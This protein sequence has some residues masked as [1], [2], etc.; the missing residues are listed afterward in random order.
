MKSFLFKY[1][2]SKIYNLIFSIKLNP[3][4]LKI[5]E[6]ERCL[7]LAAKTEDIFAAA[8]GTI[9]TNRDKFSVYSLTNGFRQIIDKDLP[10]EEKVKSRKEEFYSIVEKAQISY[11]EFFEDID[12]GRLMMRYDRFKSVIVSNFDYIFVPNI[13]ETDKDS[14]A[15]AI[16]LNEL[17]KERPYKKHVKIVMYEVNSTLPM[18][19]NYNDIEDIIEEKVEYINS[20]NQLGETDFAGNIKCLNKF[21][22]GNVHK[23]YAEAFC[24]LGIDEFRKICRLYTENR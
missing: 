9:L 12:E 24:V 11:G 1:L 7:F 20:I 19:N 22:G 18:I 4:T 14:R 3:E 8:G 5:K 2:I 10:Y 15:I 21:R 17:L 23:N 16:L 13:L 6:G